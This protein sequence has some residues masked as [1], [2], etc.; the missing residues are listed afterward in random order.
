MRCSRVIKL[1]SFIGKP[2]LDI[3]NGKLYG[4]K[5]THVS[6]SHDGDYAIAQVILET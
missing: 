1:F 2:D 4:I 6:L 5:K 3:L